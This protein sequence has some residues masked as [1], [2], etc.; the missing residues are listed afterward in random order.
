MYRNGIAGTIAVLTSAGSR[1]RGAVVHACF[2][3]WTFVLV[4]WVD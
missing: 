3:G 1:Y 4:N 2:Q